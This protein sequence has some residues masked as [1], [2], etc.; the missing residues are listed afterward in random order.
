[1]SNILMCVNSDKD[2]E[3]LIG[4]VRQVKECMLIG[5][6]PLEEVD[7]GG[8]LKEIDWAITE[9]SNDRRYLKI[10]KY[11]DFGQRKYLTK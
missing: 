1:M 3:G 2:R 11:D 6:E 7:D 9:Y 10:S 8:C 4:C 5:V